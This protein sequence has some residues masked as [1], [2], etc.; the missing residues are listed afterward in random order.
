MLNIIIFR[1]SKVAN[2]RRE[3][4]CHTWYIL[5]G[6]L[7]FYTTK[8]TN[9]C[10][11]CNNDAEVIGRKMS[12][13][14]TLSCPIMFC[15]HI[16]REYTHKWSS[17]ISLKRQFFFFTTYLGTSCYLPPTTGTS[18]KLAHVHITLFV[19]VLR[20]WQKRDDL[21]GCYERAEMRP[22]ENIKKN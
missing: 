2:N 5:F 13:V 18:E 21:A 3:R 14:L 20:R 12:N 7:I 6:Y 4:E 16:R 1:L 9:Q 17:K 10:H 22:N 11:I 8:R 15:P 19:L